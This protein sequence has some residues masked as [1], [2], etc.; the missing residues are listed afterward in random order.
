MQVVKAQKKQKVAEVIKFAIDMI[1]VRTFRQLVKAFTQ[2]ITQ[3]VGFSMGTVFFQNSQTDDLFTVT[4]HDLRSDK[5]KEDPNYVDTSYAK[6]LYF[7]DDQI[8]IFP[9]TIG[10]TGEVHHNMGFKI[11]NDYGTLVKKGNEKQNEDEFDNQSEQSNMT[12]ANI[13]RRKTSLK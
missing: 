10:I 8:V 12:P 1:E 3:L 4:D 11:D 7:P 2:N 9:S 5:A 13:M 6:E